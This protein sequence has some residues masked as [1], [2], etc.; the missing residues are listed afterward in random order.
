M[1]SEGEAMKI[2]VLM[3]T[4]LFAVGCTKNPVAAPVPGT[5]NTFDAFAAR[6]IGDAQAAILG[7][8]AWET[9]S[10]QQFPP[11]V[12]FDGQTFACDSSKTPFPASGRQYLFIAENSYNVALG[13][14]QTYHA[15]ASQ[16]TT[17]LTQAI[18][19]LGIAVSGMLT[20]VGRSK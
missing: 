14:A 18:T 7:V 1:V 20:N 11:T 9:C 6:S 15:G 5:I 2:C 12:T 16:D 13:A 17:A 19:Q 4:M 10:D 8:K 3:L